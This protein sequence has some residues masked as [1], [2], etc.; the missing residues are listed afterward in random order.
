[1]PSGSMDLAPAKLLSSLNIS[2]SEP[3]PDDSPNYG[4]CLVT[5]RMTEHFFFSKRFVEVGKV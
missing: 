2:E 5:G 1:M 4:G 3:E